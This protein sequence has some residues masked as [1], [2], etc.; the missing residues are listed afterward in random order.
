M[1]TLVSFL[2]LKEVN[3]PICPWNQTAHA[4]CVFFLLG[5][6]HILQDA[7][8]TAAGNQALQAGDVVATPGYQ[9]NCREVYH[10]MITTYDASVGAV[11]LTNVIQSCL[12]KADSSGYS[13]IAFPTLGAGGF[14]YPAD[15]VMKTFQAVVNGFEAK[16]LRTVNLVVYSTDQTALAVS[17][18]DIC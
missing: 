9:L 1:K 15:L 4:G 6:F 17:F 7:C 11:L 10:A 12:S 2:F 5:K 13:S 14:S 8:I 16:N 3:V 18:Y